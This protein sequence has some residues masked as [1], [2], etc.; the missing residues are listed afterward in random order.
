LIVRK[1]I[2][3]DELLPVG[4]IETKDIGVDLSKIEKSEQLQRYLQLPNLI[5][6]DYLEFRWYVGGKKRRTV[7]LASKQGKKIKVEKDGEAQLAE[8]FE[9]FLAQDVTDINNPRELAQRMAGLCRNIDRIITETFAAGEASDLMKDLKGA[10]SRTLL[11]EISDVQFADMF[12]QTLG[13]GLFAARIHHHQMRTPPIPPVNGGEFGSPSARGGIK[14]GLV[15]RGTDGESASG[16]EFTRMGAAREIPKSNPFLRDLFDTIHS[17]K[18][19][20]EPFIEFVDDLT[21]VL[22]HTDVEA[23]LAQF[24]KRSGQEDPILHFYETFLAAYDPAERKRRGV[25]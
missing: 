18:L 7:T 2:A 21:A 12:A 19:E 20:D 9:S 22:A 24:G 10:F 6:T 8:L 23:V 11:P 17:S 5:L 16:R 13:Y 15:S 3:R 25:Y 14:G 1:K 4:Y